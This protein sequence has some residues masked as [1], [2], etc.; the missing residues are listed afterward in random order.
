MTLTLAARSGAVLFNAANADVDTT[1][2][3]GQISVSP[4]ANANG[5]HN[6]SPVT[7]NLSATDGGSGV[8]ELR[9]WVNGGSVVV[10]NG[11]A[12]SIAVSTEG[13]TTVN[14]R[15]VDNAGNVS[16]LVTQVVKL[17][18]TKPNVSCP[19]VA[20]AQANAS[21][22]AAIPNVTSGVVAS[23]NLTPVGSLVITQTPAAGTMVGLGTHN[24]TVTVTDLAGNSRDCTTTFKVVDATAPSVTGVSASPAVLSP[25]NHKMVNVTVNYLTADNCGAGVTCTLSVTSNEPVNGADDGDTAPDWE[26]VDAHHV[27]LRAE[28]SGSGTGR[29]YTI[30]IT[31]TDAAGNQTVKTATVS[32]PKGK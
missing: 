13:T 6:S 26:I 18:V 14:L 24:I 15:A 29:I 7:V 12:T 30:T 5:W 2:P 9:Y 23:D 22:Q 28:R 4:A 11:S 25:P 27:R 16:S 17:D 31:C 21:C 10:F 8:K 3:V 20:D 32:V 19:V 1:A